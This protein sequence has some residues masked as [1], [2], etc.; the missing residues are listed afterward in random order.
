MKKKILVADDDNRILELLRL[1]LTDYELH[2]VQNGEDVFQELNK[3]TPDLIL[4]DVMMPRING[5]ETCQLLKADEKTKRIKVMLLSA[6]NEKK[7]VIEGLKC[8]ADYYFTKP[9]DT[10]QLQNRV[11]QILAF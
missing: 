10:K 9:F 5:Y 7:D 8:G 6:R 3:F 11:H 1:V 4:L 2:T